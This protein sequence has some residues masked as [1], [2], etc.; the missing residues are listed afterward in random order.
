MCNMPKLQLLDN[1]YTRNKRYIIFALS[2]HLAFMFRQ[3][4]KM[5]IVDIMQKKNN[6]ICLLAS[7]CPLE[8]TDVVSCNKLNKYLERWY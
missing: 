5:K 1:P 2:K 4:E 6:R 7:V 8:R 3:E